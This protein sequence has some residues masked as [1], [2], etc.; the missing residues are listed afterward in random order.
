[1]ITDLVT[2]HCAVGLHA[3][4]AADFVREAEKY[5]SHVRVAKDGMWANGKSILALL[6][7]AAPTGSILTLE[8]DGEDE[9]E[10]FPVLKAKL[11]SL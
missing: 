10:A 8:V 4:P 5:K 2:L 6:T 3:R 11:G 1:V 9:G 7:L